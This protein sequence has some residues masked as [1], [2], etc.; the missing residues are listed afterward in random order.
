MIRKAI[1]ILI[2]ILSII[3]LCSEHSKSA[4]LSYTT[5]SSKYG[6]MFERY[7]AIGSYED[8]SA[9]AQVQKEDAGNTSSIDYQYKF[10]YDNID[11]FCYVGLMDNTIIDI[12][13]CSMLFGV[14]G[15]PFRTDTFECRPSIAFGFRNGKI[16]TSMWLR[17]WLNY[18]Q[19]HVSTKHI[20]VPEEAEFSADYDFGID[21]TKRTSFQ[22]NISH[23]SNKEKS[24]WNF[25]AGIKVEL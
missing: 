23:I 14:A 15:S 8:H 11:Y 20:Y 5:V 7:K 4:E 24:N 1:L 9:I 10:V 21:I 19:L 22:Y 12:N 6:G 13:Y 3:I 18:E 25:S 17:N 16:N 2:L